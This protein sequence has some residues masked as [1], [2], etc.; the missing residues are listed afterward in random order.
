MSGTAGS[1]VAGEGSGGS[2][3]AGATAGVGGTSGA[4][5]G[6]NG[7]VAAD[8]ASGGDAGE[9][10]APDLGCSRGSGTTCCETVE[11]E[12]DATYTLVGW[13]QDTAY[14]ALTRMGPGDRCTVAVMHR[15]DT[16][17]FELELP[18]GWGI[19]QILD[20]P[21]DEM[22]SA[23]RRQAIG[24]LGFWDH[25]PPGSC[26]Y[27]FDFTLCFLDELGAYDSVR[28]KGEGLSLPG[29]GPEDQCP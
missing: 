27:H 15:R 20:G 12:E 4:G 6:G 25:S 28:F 21:C 5:A 22:Q 13:S 11:V 16:D 18:E 17:L 23:P 29:Y 24:A 8:G 19:D 10:G 7:G 26:A 14:L 1:A 9:G 2:G 3:A